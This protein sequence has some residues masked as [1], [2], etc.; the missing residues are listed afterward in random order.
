MKTINQVQMIILIPSVLAWAG[1]K[2]KKTEPK[3]KEE[4]QHIIQK[5]QAHIK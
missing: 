1:K 3:C 4:K 2:K 5:T